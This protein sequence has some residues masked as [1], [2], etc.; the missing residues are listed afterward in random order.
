[1]SHNYI[2]KNIKT[3]RKRLDYTSDQF[4][5]LFDLSGSNIR[6]YEKGAN[7]KLQVYLDMMKHY[8]LDPEKFC[9]LDMELHDVSRGAVPSDTEENKPVNL[10]YVSQFVP[11]VKQYGYIDDMPNDTRIKLLKSL[12]RNKEDL[13]KELLDCKGMI[14][15]L[16]NKLLKFTDL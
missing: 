3:L 9:D 8:G 15:D 12:L 11:D 5:A 16:Q 10:Q 4:G 2:S 6:S 1:M 13:Q 7:P 14:I